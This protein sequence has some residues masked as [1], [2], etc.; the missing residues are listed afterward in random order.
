MEL[1]DF[2]GRVGIRIGGLK[3]IGTAQENQQSQL[4]WTFGAPRNWTTNQITYMGWT[5]IAHMQHGLHVDP[6]Q[7][8]QGLFQKLLSV[9]GI[10][11][12]TSAAL[13][14]LSGRG[15]ARIR[16]YPGMAFTLSEER[17]RGKKFPK[18]FC[19]EWFL[20][21]RWWHLE[22]DKG[23]WFLLSLDENSK[24]SFRAR[25]ERIMNGAK[26]MTSKWHLFSVLGLVHGKIW[27]AWKIA[28]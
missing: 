1:E 18:K 19:S 10:C 17:G 27:S 26:K 13:S 24:C 2:Y 21:S 9:C 5:H 12:S 14:G 3:G 11:S 6:D 8:E 7:L 22:T 23:R 25:R 16:R 28:F 20:L 4:T 15:C